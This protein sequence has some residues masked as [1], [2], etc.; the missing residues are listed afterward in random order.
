MDQINPVTNRASLKRCSVSSYVSPTMSYYIGLLPETAVLRS[1]TLDIAKVILRKP[2]R[3]V[4]RFVHRS[5]LRRPT[6]KRSHN[7][8]PILEVVF[9]FRNSPN[10]YVEPVN[11]RHRQTQKK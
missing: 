9:A 4:C 8:R 1:S 6:V 7:C 3:H 11:E 5:V 2:T 10:V